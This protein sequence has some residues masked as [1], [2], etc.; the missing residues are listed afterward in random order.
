MQ[1]ILLILAIISV[2]LGVFN[3]F[4]INNKLRRLDYNY[5]GLPEEKEKEIN[6]IK[7]LG[8]KKVKIFGIIGLILIVLSQTIVVINTGYTGV[9]RTFGQISEE[10]V[11]NGFS[12][13]I[14]FVQSVEPVNN[15]LQDR[16][17]A[18]E[19]QIW[20]ETVNRTAIWYKDITVTYR[21]LPEK[22]AW[23]Y[24]N[25]TNYK[26]NLIT[27]SMVASSIKSASATLE[28]A[29]A[30]NRG[31]IEPLVKDMLQK[32]VNDKYGKDVIEINKVVINGADFEESYKEAIANK[33]KTQLA[34]EQQQIENQK[35]IEQSEADA[36]AKIKEAEGEAE[37]NRR[38]NESISSE[39]LQKQNL[40]NQ[41]KMLDKW[42]GELP[43]VSGGGTLMDISSIVK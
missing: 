21:I 12:L 25:V 31:S 16:P 20:G 17:V 41:N 42:N 38:L 15:K 2:G 7:K 11:P 3:L 18:T 30:T 13:K 35:K 6:N 34:Y 1:I 24:A 8:Y 33:Q 32:S 39:V 9:R 5:I 26:D 37:A 27:D 4:K 43:K 36:Q 40:D 29:Q 23:I 19:D 22:S 28:D 10:P 14:P